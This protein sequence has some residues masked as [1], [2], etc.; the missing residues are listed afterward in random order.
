[1]SDYLNE[2]IMGPIDEHYCNIFYFIALFVFISLILGI[3]GMILTILS[4]TK[5][6][7]TILLAWVTHIIAYFIIYLENRILYNMCKK[8]L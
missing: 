2:L 8:I 1:M 6:T 3:C 5:V 7:S 4:G